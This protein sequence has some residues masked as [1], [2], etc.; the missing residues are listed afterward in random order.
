MKKK[1]KVGITGGIGS[2]K[3]LISQYVESKG[4]PVIYADEVAKRLMVESEDLKNRIVEAFGEEAYHDGELNKTF[5]KEQIFSNAE[6]LR[7][8]NAI[9]HPAAVQE[10]KNLMYQRLE[11]NQI[12][13]VESALIYEAKIQHIFDYV[14]LVIASEDVRIRRILERDH[15]TVGEIRSQIDS[16]WQDSAK[17]DKADFI[18]KNE[19]AEEELYE[20]VDFIL[21]LL[22]KVL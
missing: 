19:G 18:I 4:Y 7:K 6:N 13:F 21:T 14:I 8:I 22:N 17:Q 16:Q 1:L 11:T 15:V 2:G 10:I 9:V 12:V 3:T 5:L 20:K